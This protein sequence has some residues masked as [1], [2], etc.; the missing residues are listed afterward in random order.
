MDNGG[1]E[2]V[3]SLSPREKECLLW[4]AK[5]KTS[6]ETAVIMGIS[7]NTVAFHVKNC[8]RKLDVRTRTAAV[9]TATRFGLLEL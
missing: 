1:M 9:A 4:I 2:C 7:E 6:W 5:G 8:L 3:L